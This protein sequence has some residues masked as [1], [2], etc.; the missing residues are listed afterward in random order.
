MYITH[1]VSLNLVRDLAEGAFRA[2]ED[3]IDHYPTS[4]GSPSPNIAPIQH[5]GNA[6]SP[7]GFSQIRS[8]NRSNSL[9]FG[10]TIDHPYSR[11]EESI[12]L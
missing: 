11:F 2:I 3:Y 1:L 7:Q 9:Y 5:L 4:S 6:P 12:K 10:Y 8:K